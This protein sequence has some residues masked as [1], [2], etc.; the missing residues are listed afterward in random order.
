MTTPFKEMAAVFIS[1]GWIAPFDL[2]I[3][4]QPPGQ[5]TLTLGNLTLTL[6]TKGLKEILPCI[7]SPRGS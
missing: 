4:T 2:H 1:W 7:I 5:L 3:G 6:G